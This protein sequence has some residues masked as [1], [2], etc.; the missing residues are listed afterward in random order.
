M[1]T[2]GKM[3][4]HLYVLASLPPGCGINRAPRYL[5]VFQLFI[6]GILFKF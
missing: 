3:K 1:R 4:N 5:N 6:V 2:S